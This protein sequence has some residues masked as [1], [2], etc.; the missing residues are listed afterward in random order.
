ML[1]VATSSQHSPSDGCLLARYWALRCRDVWKQQSRTACRSL[2]SACQSH[3]AHICVSHTHTPFSGHILA[4]ARVQH[5]HKRI[6]RFWDSVDIF[7]RHSS[8]DG[9]IP[10]TAIIVRNDRASGYLN[11]NEAQD[12][13]WLLSWCEMCVFTK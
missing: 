5:F 7:K 10:K 9:W 8:T 6:I 12:Y 2:Q 13:V 1:N 4:T 3:T 11:G